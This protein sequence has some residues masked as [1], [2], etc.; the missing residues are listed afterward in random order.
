MPV[1]EI[2]ERTTERFQAVEIEPSDSFLTDDPCEKN[3]GGPH[4]DIV[5]CPEIACFHCG[6]LVWA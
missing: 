6:R 2:I 1:M 5:G 3:G 4:A